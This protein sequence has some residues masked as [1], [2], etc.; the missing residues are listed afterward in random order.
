[1]RSQFGTITEPDKQTKVQTEPALLNPGVPNSP[2]LDPRWVGTGATIYNN[3]GKPVKQYEPFFSP[4]H[5]F[6]IE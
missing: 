2:I 3:K 4:T 5:H 1:M 6:G